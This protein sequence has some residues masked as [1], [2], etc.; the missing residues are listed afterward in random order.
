MKLWVCKVPKIQEWHLSV[1][2]TN[3]RY[4]TVSSKSVGNS[5]H[6]QPSN[7]SGGRPSYFAPTLAFSQ[8]C[9][10]AHEMTDAAGGSCIKVCK[11]LLKK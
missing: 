8:S 7:N 2:D 10:E 9:A 1:V 5:L 3:V 6:V 11:R 4:N